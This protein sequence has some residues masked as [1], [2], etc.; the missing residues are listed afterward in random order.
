MLALF[1]PETVPMVAKVIFFLLCV[2]RVGTEKTTKTLHNTFLFPLTVELERGLF[3]RTKGVRNFC[4]RAKYTLSPRAFFAPRWYFELRCSSLD[5]HKVNLEDTI[6][7]L[8]Q[9]F[10]IYN[11]SLFQAEVV[12]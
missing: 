1:A 6:K 10:V 8:T 12:S 11:M 9:D 4:L 7:F 5:R 2:P 3:V